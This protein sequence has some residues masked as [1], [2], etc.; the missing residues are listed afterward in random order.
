MRWQYTPLIA[1]IL[2]AVA[3]T[4][5]TEE[6]QPA[7]LTLRP[8]THV[9][10]LTQRPDRWERFEEEFGMKQEHLPVALDAIAHAKYGADIT[11]FGVNTILQRLETVLELRY[12]RGQIVTV[13]SSPP[14]GPPHRSQSPFSLEDTRL[15]VD[16]ELTSGKPYIG[17]RLVF[18]FG[19]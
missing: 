17:V 3:T 2:L 10:V 8:L 13:F 18:P 9:P 6:A 11:V 5:D 15:K 1:A 14:T 7:V 4:A 19:N 12:T 16:F